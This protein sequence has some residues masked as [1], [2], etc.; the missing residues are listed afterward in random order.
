MDILD[1]KDIEEK[2]RWDLS[3]MFPSDEAFEKA[4]EEGAAYIPKIKAYEGKVTESAETLLEYLKLS[5]DVDVLLSKIMNYAQRKSDEDT[6]VAK[7][8]DYTNK[9]MSL[10]VGISSASAW[11]TP[12]LLT[13]SDEQMEG[14]YKSLPELELYRRHLSQFFAQRAHTLSP[15]EEQ[16][17]ASAKEMASA[18]ESTYSMFAD[19]DLKFETATDSKGEKYPV[20]HG[21]FVPLE[22]SPDRVLRESAY[23]SLYSTYKNFRNTC[24]ATLSAQV[25]QLKFYA[26]ARKYNTTLEAALDD[27]EVPTEV[28]TNLIEAVHS[29]MDS[30]YKYVALRKKLLGVDELHFYD[31]YAPMISDV[32]MH[33][34]YEEACELILKAL[35]PMGE[36]YLAIVKKG[37]SERWIDVYENPGKRSGAYSAGGYG[38]NP[39]ILLN[40]H[41][42]LNDVFTLIHEMGHSV[43]TYLSSHN[44]PAVYSDYVIFVAEVASTCNEALLMQYLLKTTEDKKQKAYILNH[45]LEQFKSTLYRQCMFAE[46]ELKINQLNENGEGVTADACTEIYR[47]L[48][49]LYFGDG[50][51]IDDE[52]CH[53]WARIPHFYYN[54]YVYQYSTGFAAAMAL[55]Q[56]ILTLGEPA[57]KDYIGFLSG[58][59]SKTPIELL[60]GAG[61][62]MASPEPVL[63]AIKV[64]DG[65]IDEMNELAE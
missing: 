56:R 38:M 6:R 4:L 27:T 12:E 44:Q 61:V 37:L 15:A 25:K 62:D 30:M 54:Y 59:S 34:T 17:L 20:T 60:R 23:K 45:F 3:S 40:F 26:D 47:D 49:K 36:D 52:I 2:Y 18:A 8:Q 14:F 35:E 24:A 64:F 16:L 65:L 55:S 7:Y 42:T 41:G 19:A 43:H 58:G 29:G 11:F 22:S 28:Y 13:L 63:S 46:F 10:Y 31:I 50:I 48:Q 32:D 53:E 33:F 5:D 51:V 21:S 9:S 39:N 1:R 57:V